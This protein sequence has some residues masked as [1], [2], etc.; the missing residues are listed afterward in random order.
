MLGKLTQ[1][2]LTRANEDYGSLQTD[3]LGKKKIILGG[4]ALILDTLH[5]A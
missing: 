4:A 3:L 2:I 1:H 5:P